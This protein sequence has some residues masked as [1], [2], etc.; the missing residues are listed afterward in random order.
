MRTHLQ[1]AIDGPAGVGKST[2]GERLARKLGALYVDTGAFYRT[3][4][5]VALWQG[6]APTDAPA[7]TS[8]A[9]D[10]DIAIVPPTVADG[11]QYSVLVDGKDVTHE[12]RQPAVEAAVSRVSSHPPVR[13]ALIARMR[14]MA[15]ERSVVMVGRDIG[16]VVLSDADLKIF[17]TT[18]IEERAKRRHADLV[19]LHGPNSPS[20]DAVRQEIAQRDAIDA[21]NTRPAA[22]AITINNDNLQADEVVDRILALLG[23]RQAQRVS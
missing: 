10:M 20:L 15:N 6:V 11:R 23:E 16:T 3:L 9:A 21:P 1:I 8:L 18:S 12:L 14:S 5:Y 13:Y 19:A 7:L 4:T 2:I 22:D 17:L